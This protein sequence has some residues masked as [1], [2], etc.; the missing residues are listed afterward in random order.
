MATSVAAG[1][2]TRNRI[3][4][5]SRS[6]P[7]SS[8]VLS[9]DTLVVRLHDSF[10]RCD[11]CCFR[12]CKTCSSRVRTDCFFRMPRGSRLYPSAIAQQ[13]TKQASSRQRRRIC[14]PFT[15]NQICLHPHRQATCKVLWYL[16]VTHPCQKSSPSYSRER[17][18][19]SGQT[20]G[21]QKIKRKTASRSAFIISSTMY[22]RRTSAAAAADVFAG[23]V[24]RLPN[25]R[26]RPAPLR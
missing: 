18:L 23:A 17:G 21:S 7:A 14:Q 10:V 24:P 8:T 13:G 22:Q 5:P 4:G 12:L 11:W 2:G 16:S 6:A 25:R 26:C 9:N 1:A 3:H 20:T 15:P 19:I